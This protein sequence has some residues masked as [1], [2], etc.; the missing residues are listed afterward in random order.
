MYYTESIAWKSGR[1]HLCV[2]EVCFD[3]YVKRWEI[4]GPTIFWILWKVLR[5]SFYFK[6]RNIMKGDPFTLICSVMVDFSTI[7]DLTWSTPN[8]RAIA[9]HRLSQPDT[10]HR[11]LSW[12]G[13]H[14]KLVEQVINILHFGIGILCS[15][16]WPA[17]AA[18]TV[19][20]WCNCWVDDSILSIFAV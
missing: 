1:S 20:D 3:K 10:V 8:P 5:D 17:W 4:I 2:M 13:T 9:D 16:L 11:N 7:V 18:C 12:P 15:R 14:L 19:W 6:A